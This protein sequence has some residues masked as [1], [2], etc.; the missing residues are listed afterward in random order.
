M[1]VINRRSETISQMRVV[2]GAL[3]ALVI[4]DGVITS[5]LLQ[6][7]MARE[8]NPFLET[9]V[10]EPDFLTTKVAGAFLSALLLWHV[11]KRRPRTAMVFS[12]GIVVVYT[13]IVYWNILSFL[14]VCA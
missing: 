2:L 10:G 5:F 6:N 12:L 13:A 8:A 3:F 9:L 7:G 11:Y 4:A 14:A 1:R